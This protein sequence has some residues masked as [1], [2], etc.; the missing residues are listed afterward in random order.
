MHAL[1]Y[2]SFSFGLHSCMLDLQQLDLTSML[3]R[4]TAVTDCLMSSP[5]S[6]CKFG[7]YQLPTEE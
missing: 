7:R 2:D 3:I 6:L 5:N 4:P 1:L